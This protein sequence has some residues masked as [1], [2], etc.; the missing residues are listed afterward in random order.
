LKLILEQYGYQ[1]CDTVTNGE[2]AITATQQ[3]KPDVVLIDCGLRGP[4]DGIKAARLINSKFNVPVVLITSYDDQDVPEYRDTAQA[5]GQIFKP[6]DEREVHTAVEMALYRQQV[7][8]EL[9]QRAEELEERN[10]ELD[11]FAWAVA[12][13]IRDPINITRDFSEMLVDADTPL[14]EGEIRHSLGMIR[15]LTTGVRNTVDNLLLLATL[16]DAT[17]A[18]EP[19]NM[20]EIVSRAEKRLEELKRRYNAEIIQLG[21]W[22]DAIGHSQWVEEIWVKFISTAIRSG[23]TPP[24]LTIGATQHENEVHF[25]V[26]DN[27]PGMK[28]EEKKHLFSPFPSNRLSNRYNTSLELTVASRIASRLG[29]R[30]SIESKPGYGNTFAF[31]LPLGSLDKPDLGV[32]AYA[33]KNQ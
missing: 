3:K 5:F 18:L 24:K 25:W 20:R 8:Q 9:Q 12:H 17:V 11:A 14:A 22:P 23:G 16:R 27:G 1:I 7:E 32:H 13:E 10:A 15:E 4:M 31:T 28:E 26:R 19:V 33:G 6:F 21:P 29:S 2:D 30:L